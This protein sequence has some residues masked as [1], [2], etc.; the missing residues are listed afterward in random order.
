VEELSVL[1]IS[2]K[3]FE[4]IRPGRLTGWQVIRCTFTTTI[5]TRLLTRRLKSGRANGQGTECQLCW[6]SR[7][8][9]RVVWFETL[10]LSVRRQVA[11]STMTL[12]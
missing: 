12:R 11:S 2:R 3:V 5:G 1:Y 10:G 6:F 4:H 7:P 8:P 9:D